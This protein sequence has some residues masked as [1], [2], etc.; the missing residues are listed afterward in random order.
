[1]H[2]SDFDFDLPEELIAQRSLAPR[3]QSR[4]LVLDRAT[5]R[6]AH[7][8]FN[9]LGEYLRDDDVFVL[10]NSKVIQAR[11]RGVNAHSGGKFELLLVEELATNDWWAML[12]PG[13]RARVGTR[14]CLTDRSGSRT[15]IAACVTEANEEGH[16]R[17]QFGGTGDILDELGHLGEVPLPPY[18]HREADKSDLTCYQTVFAR[19]PGSVAAPTA[20]LH[21]TT[22][23][24]DRLRTRGIRV[25]EV[26]L[27][28]GLGTF[29]PVNRDRLEA[30]IMH[31]EP[32]EITSQV[33]NTLNEA[34]EQ[35][36]RIIAAGTTALRT[37]ESAHTPAGI[38][39]GAA[40][41]RLFAYPPFKFRAVDVLLTNFHL[42]RSTLL[43]LVSAFAAPG[44]TRGRD[45]ILK[46]YAEA[47]RERYRFF[48]YGD[49]MLIL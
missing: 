14:I 22:D 41:T 3:D 46:A 42:P 24:L 44:E 9:D 43:M 37:L 19:A 15:S 17:L 11:L 6:I 18:I 39:A 29:A 48:S 30:H 5:E 1:M 4:L 38:Q 13:K 8:K 33:A 32:Y 2:A 7:R 21:F 47:V 35:G 25:C 28:I 26:T 10:N 16:R 23:T 36:R 49:A 31:E 40:R 34:W 27:H 45:L 20:G 12:K